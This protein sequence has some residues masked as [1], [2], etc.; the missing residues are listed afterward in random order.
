MNKYAHSPSQENPNIWHDLN[1]HTQ[2]VM[3]ECARL[4]DKFNQSNLCRIVGYYHDFGKATEEWQQYLQ[5]KHLGKDVSTVCHAMCGAKMLYNNN[6]IQPK[7]N[8]PFL[9][10]VI[11]GHHAGMKNLSNHHEDMKS[12]KYNN[13]K[14]SLLDIKLES[15]D[16]SIPAGK[17]NA[18]LSRMILSVLVDADRKDTEK[19]YK[20]FLHKYREDRKFNPEFADSLSNHMSNFKSSDSE[21]IKI[22]NQ[23]Y[24]NCVDSSSLP[25]GVFFLTAPT[26]V[27]KTLASL[28]FAINHAKIHN[29]DRI[30]TVI[31][32]T[33]IIDQTKDVYQTIFDEKNVLEHHS[34]IIEDNDIEDDSNNKKSFYRRFYAENWNSPIILTTTVQFFDS[35]FSNKPSKV[36]KL[37]NICNSVIIID[38]PQILPQDKLKPIIEKLK[39]LVDNYGCTIV[40][41]SATPYNYSIKDI[42]LSGTELLPDF[43]EISKKL[44]RVNYHIINEGCKI[45][46][47]ELM[48]KE[49]SNHDQVLCIFNTKSEARDAFKLVQHK[50]NVYHLS[51]SM[52]GE[53]RLKVIKEIKQKLKNKQPCTVISTQLIECGVDLDFPIVYRALAPLPSLIQS[54]GRCNREG[55][56]DKGNFYVFVIDNNFKYRN[57]YSDFSLN[58]TLRILRSDNI[59]NFDLPSNCKAYFSNIHQAPNLSDEYQKH[60]LKLEFSDSATFQIINNSNYSVLTEYD[61]KFVNTIKEELL[62]NNGILN[63]KTRKKYQILCVNL[64]YDESKDIKS[65][66]EYT[67]ALCDDY[68][69]FRIW[70]YGYDYNIGI[71]FPDV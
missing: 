56:L 5:D 34:N 46:L 65:Y 39:N 58:E 25:K 3:D 41:C 17:Q 21:L 70:K 22:R 32:F 19:F 64:F 20:P 61:P 28:G 42:N 50:E 31:P 67:E 23:V 68:P 47:S 54:A 18:L 52:V 15:T 29:C 43:E 8:I 7:S 12:E 10:P 44:Q 62:V 60:E 36:R 59:Y 69:E 66:Y 48:Q 51:T 71:I 49:I 55:K 37:H 11:A 27:G 13:V 4:G 40:L 14:E 57:I 9:F 1:E 38:E 30:I 45:E 35:L 63:E 6:N 16:I 2:C 53:H 26:G 24:K 33:S